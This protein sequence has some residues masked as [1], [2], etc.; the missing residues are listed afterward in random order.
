MLFNSGTFVLFF[1]AFLALYWLVR[2][3]LG[4]RNLLI[5]GASWL[6]YGWW[7]WRFLALLV[8]SSLLDYGLGIAVEQAKGPARRRWVGLSLV[9]NLG[10]L[11]I[12]KYFNFFAGS[13]ETLITRLGGTADWPTL[14]VVLPVGIS[15]YT[16]Q[17][18]GYVLDVH[19]GRVRACRDVVQFLGYVAFFPQLVAGPIERAAHM[20]PQFASPRTVTAQHL[21]DGIWLILLGL[22]RKVVIADNC[23]IVADLAFEQEQFSAPVVLVGIVAFSLQIYGDFAGYSD[24][25]RGTAR[26]LGF[27]LMVNFAEP[28]LA[29]SIREFWQRWHISL[30]EWLRDNIYIPLGG[31]RSGTARTVINLIL[32]LFLGGL[33]HGAAWHFVAWGGWHGSGLAV[34][35]LWA[36]TGVVV[37]RMI[38]WLLTL[39][40]VGAGWLLFRAP[41]LETVTSMVRAWNDLSAPAWLAGACIQL[42]WFGVPS[43]ALDLLARRFG[44]PEWGAGIPR[45]PRIALQGV[46][47]GAVLLYW[48]PDSAAFLYFQF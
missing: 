28:Y 6:F 23:G 40:F 16:F 45:V 42:A 3:S 22:F 25:A 30:S 5:V 8:G 2:G 31:N 12:F 1:L 44:T 24:I 20:L 21:R 46:L 17:S 26:L 4:G 47:L 11:G 34:R 14:N 41:D 48:C 32:T 10:L 33:W 19:R 15:F 43:I 38:G 29:G 35:T 37:P 9:V 39:A 36:R 7:D 27:E 18:L 13:L